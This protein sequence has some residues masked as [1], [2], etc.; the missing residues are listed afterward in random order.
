M[1]K[2]IST[3]NNQPNSPL[4]SGRSKVNRSGQSRKQLTLSSCAVSSA[5]ACRSISRRVRGNRKDKP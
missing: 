3:S 5:K 2:P 4:I 1:S